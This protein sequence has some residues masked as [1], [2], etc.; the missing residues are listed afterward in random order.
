MELLL[1]EVRPDEV[2]QDVT[3]RD[4]FNTDEVGLAETLVREAHQNTMDSPSPEN[5][6]AVRTRIQVV[7]SAPE[8]VGFWLSLLEPLRPHLNSCGIDT[9][10]VELGRPR[11]LVIEDFGTTGLL[12]AVDRKD[13]RNFSDFWR[14][15]GRS[16]KRGSQGG[17]WGLGKL[18]FSSAS[19]IRTFFGL[20][21]Q[22]G[23]P[24]GRRY[25]M[26]QAV[27]RNHL[28]NGVNYAP[29]AFFGAAAADGLQIPVTAPAIVD[30]FTRA[31]AVTRTTQPGLSII[32]PCVQADLTT[33][34]L[35][36][37]VIR[38]WFFP[39]LTGKLIV[40]IGEHTVDAASFEELARHY[41]GRELQDGQIIEFIRDVKTTG[42]SGPT[43]TLT[44]ASPD[45]LEALDQD[46]LTSLRDTYATGNL[47]SVRVPLTLRR[48]VGMP[49]QTYVDGYLKAAPQKTGGDA[50][51]VRGALTLPGESRGFRGRGCLAA[52]V[53]TEKVVVEFLGDAEN[54]AHT[55]WIGTAE[56]LTQRWANPGVRLREVRAILNTLY[57]LIAE[58]GDR[59][60][61]DALLDFFSVKNAGVSEKKHSRKPVVR[62]PT[63]PP[64]AP[65][66]PAYRIQQ[67]TGGFR[68]TGGI[69]AQVPFD[70]RIRVAYDLIRGEPLARFN[71]L[72]F[73]FQKGDVTIEAEG[74]S[75]T[76]VSA[77]EL[78]IEVHAPDFSV[79]VSGFDPERDLF[80]RADRQ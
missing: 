45:V 78:R 15:M 73:D 41:G 63:V 66:P 57:E 24:T 64:I 46:L 58:T 55:R 26:G 28:L 79:I 50:I 27:L 77:N 30:V 69:G 62:K 12:G 80:L 20:T 67:R 33:D 37:H 42:E 13:E 11:L 14:R 35:L 72:D 3:Q 54:P 34:A 31:A 49:L 19:R 4:Q 68:V 10:G 29:H 71:P 76:V 74:A 51:F 36:P 38:N 75:V 52:L 9:A 61:E 1:R 60:H 40:E 5:T 2:E 6:G 59:V 7:D 16:H 23:D 22:E 43:V 17:R 70:V 25:L 47:V 21:I 18:V 56:K 53:A 44:G 32:V 48:K 65:R 8:D 39:I